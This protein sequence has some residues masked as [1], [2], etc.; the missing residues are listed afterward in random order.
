MFRSKKAFTL[1]ELLVV[2]AIIGILATVSIISLSDA[3]AKSRDA[4]RAGD[5][6]QIQTALELFFNDNNRYPTSTEWAT[7]QI[8]ST[9]SSGTSTYMQAIPSAPTPIDGGCDNSQN[10]FY[11]AQTE[12]G[13]S[14]TISFCL[15]NTTGTLTAGPKCL[16]PGGIVDVDCTPCGSQLVTYGGYDYPTVL[17]G[18][19][20]WLAENLN[21][22]SFIGNGV[23]AVGFDGNAG[24]NDDCIDVSGANWWSCQGYVGVQKYCYSDIANNCTTDGGLYEWAETLGLPSDCNGASSVD[25]GD[26]TFTL[27][28]PTSGAQTILAEQQGICPNGWHVPS[29]SDWQTLEQG[30]ATDPNCDSEVDGCTPAGGKLKETGTTHWGSPNTEATNSSGFTA[31]PAGMRYFY[32]SFYS[33]SEGTLLW[34]TSPLLS[35]PLYAWYRFLSYTS[36]NISS[37]SDGRRAY[38]LSVR[39]LK[40]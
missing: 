23:S 15:G 36:S 4:K 38:G 26:G 39:C 18:N 1:I 5:I 30:L 2:I 29:D 33:R 16:T 32:S 7:G 31:L 17:I 11:Y 20:C 13:N 6:K 10:T 25:N 22:G 14:Y 40:N 27:T 28:C 3:R 37:L 12:G 19:Q 24:T 21:V 8:F 9:S 34:S 35:D